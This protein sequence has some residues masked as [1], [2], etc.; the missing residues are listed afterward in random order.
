VDFRLDEAALLAWLNSD[1]G[2]VGRYLDRVDEEIVSVARASVRVRRPG[3][4]TGRTSNA[5][6]PG[7]T[8][9]SIRADKHHDA[10]G[11]IYG[12]ARAAADPGIFLEYPAEQD[13]RKYPFLTTG[14]DAARRVF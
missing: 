11:L 1:D 4:R 14:L 2:P 12:G 8:L 3:D 9:A 7:Y 5:R 10:A 6:P 13:R